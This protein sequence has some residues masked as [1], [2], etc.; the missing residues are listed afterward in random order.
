MAAES[1]A[2]LGATIVDIKYMFEA[3]IESP[4]DFAVYSTGHS[5]HISVFAAK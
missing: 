2:A 1:H 5:P 4:A 3:A